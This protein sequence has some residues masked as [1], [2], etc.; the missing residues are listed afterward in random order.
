MI[1]TFTKID[2]ANPPTPRPT[3]MAYVWQNEAVVVSW[4]EEGLTHSGVGIIVA[5]TAA[6]YEKR[7]HFTWAAD[8]NGGISATEKDGVQEHIWNDADGYPLAKLYPVWRCMYPS[9]KLRVGNG[10]P[11]QPLLDAASNWTAC[12]IFREFI[13][14]LANDKSRDFQNAMQTLK[15]HIAQGA[16]GDKPN[17]VLHVMQEQAYEVANFFFNATESGVIRMNADF[18]D[19]EAI[20]GAVQVMI[21]NIKTGTPPYDPA[22]LPSAIIASY[23]PART[24]SVVITISGHTNGQAVEGTVLTAT[25]RT[26]N[27]KNAGKRAQ[28]VSC[29]GSR[30]TRGVELRNGQE[31]SYTVHKTNIGHSICVEISGLVNAVN[32]EALPTMTSPM[33]VECVAA[34]PVSVPAPPPGT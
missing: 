32:G 12:Q 9:E 16:R 4:W 23:L 18:A 25:I 27:T 2:K 5:L 6:E 13:F 22:A 30:N 24:P 28:W 19:L 15:Q 8:A 29:T 34:L 11:D 1:K 21:A 3:H 17:D 14:A 7:E 26:R 20:E 31:F 10:Q 33:S